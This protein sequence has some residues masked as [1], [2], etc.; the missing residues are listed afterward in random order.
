FEDRTTVPQT[1]TLG[2]LRHQVLEVI[3]PPPQCFNCWKFG[4]FAYN[5]RFPTACKIC[6]GRHNHEECNSTR[7]KCTNCKQ[8]HRAT[9]TGCPRRKTYIS[10]RRQV[11]QTQVA[12]TTNTKPTTTQGKSVQ[13]LE[14]RYVQNNLTF[15]Q[16][17][18][19]VRQEQKKPQMIS[20]QNTNTQRD[21][22]ENSEPRTTLSHAP[23]S[24]PKRVYTQGNNK[25][26]KK[27]N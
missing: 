21:N 3:R 23:T 1:I 6:G 19:T 17:L 8:G 25:Q 26:M 15:A 16:A 11:L 24:A 27:P 18:K 9:Y 7:E 14:N 10:T 20:T 2:Y 12:A 22:V 5:C 4:H 13:P